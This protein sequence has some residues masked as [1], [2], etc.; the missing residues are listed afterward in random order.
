MNKNVI[1]MPYWA[2]EILETLKCSEFVIMIFVG[3]KAQTLYCGK[4][5]YIHFAV[6][7]EVNDKGKPIY[8]ISYSSRNGIRVISD[9][10]KTAITNCL[11]PLLGEPVA[12][13]GGINCDYLEFKR[14][15]N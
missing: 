5:H 7:E 8:L 6:S 10:V 13:Y 3:G 14:K 4:N 12:T 2:K 15:V 1:A 9:L 11:I